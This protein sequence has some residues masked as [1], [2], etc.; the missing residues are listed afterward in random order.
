MIGRRPLSI[1]EAQPWL[2]PIVITLVCYTF[3]SDYSCYTFDS[4]GYA[5]P[6]IKALNEPYPA[7]VRADFDKIMGVGVPPLVLFSTIA[8]SDRAWRKFKGG[9]LLDGAL[10]TLRQ[11][12]LVI[13]RVC[14]RTGC[15][16]EWGVH[17]MAFAQAAGLSKEEIAGTLEYPLRPGQWKDEEAALLTA[18]DA[19][20]D[21]ATLSDEAFLNLRKHF[22]DDQIL[23]VLML[24]GFYR[25][26][27]YI[28]NGLALPLE[29]NAASFSEY[30]R[31]E[32]AG[33]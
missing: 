31:G 30:H 27:S 16:Y 13:D 24:A 19:L 22:D 7:D 15:E 11:R 21:R 8:S 29:Q 14:A 28:A 33:H 32:T 26:V 5:M 23:E 2:S 3:S 1:D 12:E 25:T 17:V 20:H 10:L 18:V 4:R 6:R 9:S